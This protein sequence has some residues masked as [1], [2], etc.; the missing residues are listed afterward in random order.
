MTSTDG[1]KTVT[2]AL[3]AYQAALAASGDRRAFDLLYK[4]WHPKLMRFALRQTG[5]TEAAKDVMQESA[6]AI[7][8]NIH[9]LSDPHRFSAWAYT[10][11]RRRAADH[12]NRLV[13]DRDKMDALSRSDVQ[14]PAP[15]MDN[16]LSLKQVLSKMPANDRLLLTL[17]YVDGLKAT[18][19]SAAM[20]IPLG[21]VKS[22]LFAARAKLK[23]IYDNQPTPN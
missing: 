10:I 6:M 4:R 21:T 12:I 5:N 16:S 20:G 14:A 7:A 15:D 3:D 19:L 8:K 22:R 2:D 18:E 11:V 1:H 13:K 17:F 9:R 23:S